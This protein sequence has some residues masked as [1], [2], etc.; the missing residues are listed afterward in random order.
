MIIFLTYYDDSVII[1]ATIISLIIGV[2]L[3]LSLKYKPYNLNNLNKLDYYSTNVC[4]ASIALAVGIY[5][6]E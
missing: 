1:K 2:Y 6:S 3:E 5:V 4:L